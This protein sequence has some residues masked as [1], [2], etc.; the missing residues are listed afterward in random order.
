M[1]TVELLDFLFD[2]NDGILTNN[3]DCFQGL[4]LPN[5]EVTK[6]DCDADLFLSSLNSVDLLYGMLASDNLDTLPNGAG[7]IYNL[8]CPSVNVTT[9][10][11]VTANPCQFDHIYSLSPDQDHQPTVPSVSSPSSSS[12]LSSICSGLTDNSTLDGSTTDDCHSL[13]PVSSHTD[14]ELRASPLGYG[15]EELMMGGLLDP[16]LVMTMVVHSDDTV[17]TMTDVG[18][19]CET[20]FDDNGLISVDINETDIESESDDSGDRSSPNDNS[21]FFDFSFMSSANSSTL[22]FTL[23]DTN[24]GIKTKSHKLILSDEEKKL[25]AREGISLPTDLP[26]TKD[27]ERAL[28][29]VRRKIRNKVSAKVSRKRKQEYVEGLEKRVKICT[30]QNRQLQQKVEK[31]EKQNQSFLAQLK[32]LHAMIGSSGGVSFMRGVSVRQAQTGTCIMVLL[33]SFT[34]FVLPSVGPWFTSQQQMSSFDKAV[35]PGRSRNLLEHASSQQDDRHHVDTVHDVSVAVM[36]PFVP[37]GVVTSKSRPPGLGPLPV[38]T[39]RV[40][41]DVTN[42]TGTE[43][44]TDISTMSVLTQIAD[45]SDHESGMDEVSGLDTGMSVK[46]LKSPSKN[47]L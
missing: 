32:K 36:N 2:Q 18:G 7:D 23:Q 47:D 15:T 13:S 37:R 9:I 17:E 35:A 44:L 29:T 21:S 40:A 28:K 6:S 43:D 42:E 3:D 45:S 14:V 33:L 1:S 4:T 34:F 38:A 27:E 12:H 30:M 39:V 16:A 8:E 46:L 24:R 22:P 19:D 5:D 31:L 41:I 20:V 10:T 11:A 26:L 25:L